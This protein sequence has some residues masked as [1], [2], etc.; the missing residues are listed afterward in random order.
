MP[1]SL[2]SSGTLSSG[3]PV[4]KL[5]SM[6]K[7]SIYRPP[8]QNLKSAMPANV[9]FS[10]AMSDRFEIGLHHALSGANAASV[11][12]FVLG[13]VSSEHRLVRWIKR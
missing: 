12:F 7:V 1:R 5:D 9:Y 8:N 3:N 2:Y 6:P 11:H 4:N 13:S 10:P